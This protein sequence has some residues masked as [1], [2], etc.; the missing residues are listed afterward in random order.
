MIIK[1]HELEFVNSVIEGTMG[2]KYKWVN[3]A[4]IAADMFITESEG[5]EVFFYIFR[6]NFSDAE[7]ANFGANIGDKSMLIQISNYND[8]FEIMTRLESVILESLADKAA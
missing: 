2:G 8:G 7:T 4:T 1:D 3:E 5:T 6:S